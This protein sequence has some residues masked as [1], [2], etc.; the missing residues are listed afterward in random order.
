MS[1]TQST[2]IYAIVQMHEIYYPGAVMKTH[3]VAIGVRKILI[4]GVKVKGQAKFSTK[5]LLKL[6]DFRQF[7]P[8]FYAIDG[9][10]A[11]KNREYCFEIVQIC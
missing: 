11:S 8:F 1:S 3:L 2:I 10:N 5:I 6:G 7:S 9:E 4:L